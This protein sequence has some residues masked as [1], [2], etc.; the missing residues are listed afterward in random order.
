[1]SHHEGAHAVFDETDPHG[2]GGH[3]Q[4][5]S[6]VIVGPMQLRVTLAILLFFTALTVA[7]AWAEQWVIAT[8]HI[9]MPW[10]VNVAGA[11]SI[12]IIK[13]LLVMAI[14][15]Q[16]RYDN[17]M[18]S[19]IMAFTFAAL[20]VFL[21]FTG[22]DLFNRAAVEDWKFRPVHPGGTGR[23][24]I[25][26]YGDGGLV[27]GKSPVEAA[28][29]R[30]LAALEQRLGSKEAALAEFERQRAENSHA[31]HAQDHGPLNTPNRSRPVVGRTDALSTSA[32]APHGDAHAPGA[33]PAPGG[34]AQ[35]AGH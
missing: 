34:H 12:A 32:P 20:A 5:A 3:G 15:M 19:I 8:L 16:L 9:P 18:N 31:A 14:F 17:P 26:P 7:F 10:W 23:L 13:S 1:M 27:E 24:V 35:P 22:L 33:K 11:M 6:H 28:R 29:I 21:T 2:A 30:H 25:Y 4:H